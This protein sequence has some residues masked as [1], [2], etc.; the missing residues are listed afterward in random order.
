M[1]ACRARYSSDRGEAYLSC[2]HITV[3]F[4]RL[5]TADKGFGRFAGLTCRYL[6]P[7]RLPREASRALPSAHAEGGQSQFLVPS[8]QL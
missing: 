5:V 8:V 2:P 6:E 4:L 1:G 3:W 7:W